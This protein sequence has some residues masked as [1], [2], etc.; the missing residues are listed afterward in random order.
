MQKLIEAYPPREK[1]MKNDTNI[2]ER[3]AIKPS[4]R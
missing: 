1:T 3:E 2:G 4:A